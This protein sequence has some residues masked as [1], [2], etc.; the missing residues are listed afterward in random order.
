MFPQ[1]ESVHYDVWVNASWRDVTTIH[2]NGSPGRL[3]RADVRDALEAAKATAE[4]RVTF[5]EMQEQTIDGRPAWGWTERLQT[6]SLGLVWIGYR[7]AVPYDTITYTIELLSGDPAL[8]QNPDTLLAIA[9]TF[10]VGEVRWNF[11]LIVAVTILLV[12]LAGYTRRKQQEKARRL[13]EITLKRVEVQ[14]KDEEDEPPQAGSPPPTEEPH[15]P[16]RP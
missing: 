12:I 13:R 5:G 8:K 4:A 16:P 14:K 1:R 10:A 11:P 7:V 15:P 9:E 3:M 6:D 2:I